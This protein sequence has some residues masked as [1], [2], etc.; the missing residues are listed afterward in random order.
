MS[1]RRIAVWSSMFAM[2]TMAS[3]EVAAQIVPAL[4]DSTLAAALAAIPGTPLTLE[5]A[6]ARASEGA[7][8]IGTARAALAAA[9]ASRRAEDGGFDPEV[10]ANFD[11]RIEDEATASPFAGA[12]VLASDTRTTEVGARLHLLTGGDVKASIVTQRSETNSRFASLNPSYDSAGQIEVT[13]PLLA[14]LGPAARSAQL[15]ARQAESAARTQYEAAEQVVQARVEST[16][17]DLYAAERDLAV[18]RLIRDRAIAFLGL[19]E[20]RA[21]VGIVGPYQVANARA[22]LAQE[23]QLVIDR[24]EE[25]DA[26]S[27]RL[28]TL[29]G[30]RPPA[31]DARWR[32]A[33]EPPISVALAPQDSVVAWALRRNHDLRA[34]EARV[35]A[36]RELARGGR[37]NALPRLDLVGSLGGNGLAG[38][39]RD[40]VFGADTLRVN[41]KGN[42]FGDS[43]S[44][45][46]QRDFPTWSAGVR[47]SMPIG[48]RA[49][50]AE[51]DRLRAEVER[52]G[53][54]LES[55]RRGVEADVR[56]RHRELEHADRRRQLARDGVA[57][58][59]EQLRIVE[60]EYRAGRSTAFEIVRLGTDLA[61]ANRRYS[62]A[63][64]QAARA[65][66]ELRRLTSGAFPQR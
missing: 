55:L 15:A 59:L 61:D 2:L 31:G 24:E 50:R 58:S 19:V 66:A 57:A 53:F 20:R 18:E 22:F 44:Q 63:L 14:G 5:D 30:A 11:K 43:W 23:E 21:R 27:D 62:D 48:L 47:L 35:A 17:W 9:T 38:T 40:V 3:F 36:A 46:L 25:L 8:E 13:Q 6:V 41:V 34:V 33:T 65:A 29:L 10:F 56:A 52:A 1:S 54:E 28:A 4:P 37:R 49:S 60:L 39:G 12:D 7:T 64:V 42:S 45:V 16:Y 26:T 51:S 32:S